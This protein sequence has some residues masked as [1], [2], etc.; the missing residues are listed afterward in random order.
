MPASP[1]LKSTYGSIRP[2]RRSLINRLRDW[3]LAANSATF[4]SALSFSKTLAAA[5]S[6]SD[7]SGRLC[8]L[9]CIIG[10]GGFHIGVKLDGAFVP[11]R[12]FG[13]LIL[14]VIG[15]ADKECGSIVL[16]LQFKGLRIFRK[17]LVE[18]AA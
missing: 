9:V 13:K 15:I 7:S 6:A 1:K 5:V 16:R 12:A 4:L 3:S 17:G 8:L 10:V 2:P 11:F 18:I 14:L